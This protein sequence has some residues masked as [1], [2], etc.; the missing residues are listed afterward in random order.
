M[1]EG[2]SWKEE[3]F[4][5]VDVGRMEFR[6]GDGV[7]LSNGLSILEWCSISGEEIHLRVIQSQEIPT[8]QQ[9]SGD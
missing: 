1:K 6:E 4:K 8:D 5:G 7:P 2:L 9:G 3:Y